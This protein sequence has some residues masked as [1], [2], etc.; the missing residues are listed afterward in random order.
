MAIFQVFSALFGDFFFF[1]FFFFFVL[2]VF[3]VLWVD[4]VASIPQ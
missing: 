4:L 1:S 3:M 2:E